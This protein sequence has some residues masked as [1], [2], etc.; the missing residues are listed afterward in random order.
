MVRFVPTG[1]V[2]TDNA[3]EWFANGAS[4]VAM[5]SNLVPSDGSLDG[6]FER[7]QRAVAASLLPLSI[8]DQN[9]D[10]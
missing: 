7:A 10:E 6:L 5:G 8:R 9:A 2:S 4:A 1:G 3:H